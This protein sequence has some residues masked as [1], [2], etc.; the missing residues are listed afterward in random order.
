M[1]RIT[2]TEMATEQRWTLEGRLVQPWVGE[3]RANWK[4]RNR[5]ENGRTCTVDLS[6]ITCIDNSGLRLLRTMSKEGT[7]FIA[8][9]I[10]TKHAPFIWFLCL[11]AAF[12]ANAIACS[13]SML[14][15]PELGKNNAKHQFRAHMNP[16]NGSDT[17]TSSF[18]DGPGGTL[19]QHS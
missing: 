6:Q 5:P 11:F 19:C 1:L 3:L 4:N 13:P 15:N 10:Y 16:N 8:T 7:N 18:S 2:I 17:G 14:A 12:L 9:G